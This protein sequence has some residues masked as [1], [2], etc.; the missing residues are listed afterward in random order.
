MC[1]GVA[2]KEPLALPAPESSPIIAK[3]IEQL[4]AQHHVPV[5]VALAA[6]NVDDHP[7][8]VDVMNL[9]MSSLGAA[10]SGGI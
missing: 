3:R 2:G 7:P 4:G 10:R 1:P 8:A 5:A 6:M 9:Q